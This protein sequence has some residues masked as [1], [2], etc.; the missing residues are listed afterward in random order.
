M[1]GALLPE[2]PG[3]SDLQDQETLHVDMSVR[4]Y[5]VGHETTA[6]VIHTYWYACGRVTPHTTNLLVVY[7]ATRSVCHN[8]RVPGHADAYAIPP[9][10]A[11]G[12]P[13]E[14]RVHCSGGALLRGERRAL[15]HNARQTKRF[16]NSWWPWACLRPLNGGGAPHAI[17]RLLWS[18]VVNPKLRK[19]PTRRGKTEIGRTLLRS[20]SPACCVVRNR[21]G[22]CVTSC[23]CPPSPSPAAYF[24]RGFLSRFNERK[25]QHHPAAARRAQV[26]LQNHNPSFQSYHR[27]DWYVL[28]W[29]F[30]RLGGQDPFTTVHTK[31]PGCQWHN[32][33]SPPTIRS[34]YSFTSKLQYFTSSGIPPLLWPGL[35][36]CTNLYHIVL[37]TTS[38]K[39]SH[40]T[41]HTEGP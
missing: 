18:S 4:Q 33:L 37:R 25:L 5:W 19:L 35:G 7:N 31:I 30:A 1:S 22:G 21:H 38:L 41:N 17:A 26:A 27:F 32:A 10:E 14:S 23:P 20:G 6:E 40:Q 12:H 3:P 16:F 29:H 24:F 34:H 8:C 9:D 15:V 36:C 39:Q 11:G 13:V 2:A 28:L